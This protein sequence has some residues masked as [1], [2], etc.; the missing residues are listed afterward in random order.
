[1]GMLDELKELGVDVDKALKLLNGKTALYE[2]L[3]VKFADM[4]KKADIRTDF[5]SS[6][7]TAMMETTHMIK[8]SAGNL[9][10]TPLFKAYSDIMQL[11][12]EGKPE[13]AR[14]GLIEILPVQETIIACIDKYSGA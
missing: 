3:L 6:Y 1:M 9:S 14:E 2:K 13:E 10:I 4:M 5:D 8:G 7:C 11:F 12:R